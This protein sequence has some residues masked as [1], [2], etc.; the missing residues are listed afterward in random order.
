MQYRKLIKALAARDGKICTYCERPVKFHWEPGMLPHSHNAAT[1]EHY[2]K[3]KKEG[4]KRT[5]RNGKLACHVCNNYRGDSP[6]KVFRERLASFN[7]DP[8]KMKAHAKKVKKAKQQRKHEALCLRNTLRTFN[9]MDHVSWL[10]QFIIR[11]NW[12]LTSWSHCVM[13]AL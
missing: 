3:L 8:L 5:L 7:N 13:M 12:R 9:R 2:Y 11:L 4:G 1:Y 10:D 6:V